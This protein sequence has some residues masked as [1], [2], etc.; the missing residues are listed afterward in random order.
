M[1]NLA[2]TCS[3]FLVKKQR[4]CSFKCYKEST[5]CAEHLS[6]NNSSH[7]SRIKC[8][9][10]PNQY[11]FIYHSSIFN[12]DLSRHLKICNAKVS[13]PLDG[14]IKNINNGNNVHLF[15]TRAEK[16]ISSE[17]INRLRVGF[18]PLIEPE[19]QLYQKN[20]ANKHIKQYAS[21]MSTIVAE[22]IKTPT[23]FV[24]L[25]AGKAGLSSF[26]VENLDDD[27]KIHKVYAFDRCNRRQ[28]KDCLIKNALGSDKF[29]R[30]KV[31]LADFDFAKII[32][33]NANIKQFVFYSKHLCG[34]ATCLSLRGI[35]NAINFIKTDCT[36]IR[37]I[38]L[39]ATCC[40]H[41]CSEKDFYCLIDDANC[42]YDMN[43]C[44]EN[45]GKMGSQAV[46]NYKR[47]IKDG[48]M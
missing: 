42:V 21:L 31:D 4:F 43:T 2:E 48:D 25:G 27:F 8:P 20:T 12:H 16:E 5:F 1:T 19:K 14:Y 37:C 11:N 41:L 6:E 30:I 26:I 44:F 32:K 34:N 36:G 9:L 23:V 47:E 29:E 18:S 24:E 45:I 35:E 22:L 28:K 40:H 3:F 17:L 38:V 33:D 10:D 13:E 39:I 46:C 15:N 7:F